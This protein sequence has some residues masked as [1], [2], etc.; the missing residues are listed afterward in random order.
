MVTTLNQCHSRQLS[1]RTQSVD[2]DEED[3]RKM[4]K[5]KKTRG[6]TKRKMK[7]E[8]LSAAGYGGQETRLK[9]SLSK[10]FWK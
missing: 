10:S 4:Q 5:K 9:M 1:R 2:T 7:D 6:A 3:T 8:E